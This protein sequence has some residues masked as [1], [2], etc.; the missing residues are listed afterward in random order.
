MDHDH[1][2]DVLF[3]CFPTFANECVVELL[4]RRV[5][6]L[7]VLIFRRFAVVVLDG[8]CGR[9]IVWRSTGSGRG[10]GARNGRDN[11]LCGEKRLLLR[12]LTLTERWHHVERVERRRP[13]LG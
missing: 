3:W 7:F 13:W 5:F 6:P 11:S 2:F 1:G 12:R 8:A 9:C 10:A 4:R